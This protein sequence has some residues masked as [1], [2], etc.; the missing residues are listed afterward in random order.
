M[1]SEAAMSDMTLFDAIYGLRATRIFQDRPIPESEVVP[2]FEMA[3][4]EEIVPVS[5][6]H[7]TTRFQAPLAG[8]IPYRCLQ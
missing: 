2:D 5:G 8:S 6:R 7:A 4:S 1:G 3:G